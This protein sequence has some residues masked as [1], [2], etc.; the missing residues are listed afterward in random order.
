MSKNE[1]K[2][3]GDQRTTGQV[4]DNDIE[5]E[6][7]L[8]LGGLGVVSGFMAGFFGIGGM[9]MIYVYA[10]FIQKLFIIE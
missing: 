8:S 9:R 2:Q 7:I 3:D 4:F 1:S 6:N 5:L 10:A